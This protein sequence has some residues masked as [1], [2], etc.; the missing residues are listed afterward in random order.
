MPLSDVKCLFTSEVLD[1]I[2]MLLSLK[3]DSGFLFWEIKVEWQCSDISAI[4]EAH[5]TNITNTIR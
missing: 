4:I 5:L 3:F 2:I 1:R